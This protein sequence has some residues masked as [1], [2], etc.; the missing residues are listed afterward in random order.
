MAEHTDTRYIER[1]HR[2]EVDRADLR[3]LAAWVG[4]F[5]AGIL[6]MMALHRLYRATG[7]HP[8]VTQVIRRVKHYARWLIPGVKGRRSQGT[9]PAISPPHYAGSSPASGHDAQRANA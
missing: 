9:P 5:F 4:V 2:P 3:W 1:R 8:H 6:T 7:P